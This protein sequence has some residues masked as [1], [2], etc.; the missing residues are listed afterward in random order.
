L[1]LKLN[2][3]VKIPSA[4]FFLIVFNDIVGVASYLF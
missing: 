4:W 1:H 3:S 2:A